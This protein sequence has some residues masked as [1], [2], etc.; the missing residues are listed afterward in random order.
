MKS[1]RNIK[2]QFVTMPLLAVEYMLGSR[3][4]PCGKSN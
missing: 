4:N 3:K 1:N 2:D